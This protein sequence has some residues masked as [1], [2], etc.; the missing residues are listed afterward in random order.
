VKHDG[1]GVPK[2]ATELLR[3]SRK[4]LSASSSSVHS[5]MAWAR[6]TAERNGSGGGSAQLQKKV[7]DASKVLTPAAFLSQRQQG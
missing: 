1:D 2:A 7:S 4:S 3:R 6:S 5:A